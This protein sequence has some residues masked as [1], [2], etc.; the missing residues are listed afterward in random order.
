VAASVNS[1]TTTAV[2]G[3]KTDP[4]SLLCRK[5]KSQTTAFTHTNLA[6]SFFAGHAHCECH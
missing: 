4:E 1:A 3:F 6:I 2:F 5:Q